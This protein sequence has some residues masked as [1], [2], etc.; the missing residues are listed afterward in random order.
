MDLGFMD[1]E[2]LVV[3][4]LLISL[5]VN[6]SSH[7]WHLFQTRA[8]MILLFCSKIILWLFAAYGVITQSWASFKLLH[9]ISQE[10]LGTPHTAQANIIISSQMGL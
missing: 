9:N 3:S 2:T 4:L 8:P 7:C 5:Y 1:Q 6:L 10:I